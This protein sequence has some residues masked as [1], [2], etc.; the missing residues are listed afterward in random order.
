MKKSIAG[1]ALMFLLL[2]AIT[3]SQTGADCA[4][5]IT[6]TLDGVCRNYTT[7]ATVDTTLICTS[8]PYSGYSPVT[9]FSFTTDASASKVLINITTPTAQPCEVLLYSSGSCTPPLSASSMCFNDGSGLWAFG[10]AF[11]IFPNTTYKL[12]IKTAVAGNITLCAQNITVANDDCAGATVIG[13]TPVTENNACHTAGPGV[14]AAELCAGSLENT[15]FYRYVVDISGATI[16][17]ITSIDCDNGSTNN[18][19]GMQIGF[20]TGNCSS[21]TPLNCYTDVGTNISATTP[22]LAAGTNVYVAI[23]GVAGSNCVYQINAINAMVLP[24]DVKEFA[25][26]KKSTSNL[27]TWTSALE[28]KNGFFEMERSENGRDFVKIGRVNL[29][30]HE[31]S[32]R[33]Y[34][35]EDAAAP[36]RCYYRLKFVPVHG[37]SSY[38]KSILVV[39]SN[40]QSMLLTFQNPVSNLLTFNLETKKKSVVSLRI[41]SMS[42]VVKT[43][44]LVQCQ[45]GTNSFT[46]SLSTFAA[47]TYLLEAVLDDTRTSRLFLKTNGGQ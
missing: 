23:D 19:T 31:T 12:R 14:T 17:N 10:H 27:L 47:G 20:F 9:F 29:N 32:N 28:I 46:Q 30:V 18:S 15:A 26:W 3:Y 21:L 25:A 36:A 42:G 44:K 38:S 2:P 37:A 33:K 34:Q 45:E 1:V 6:L 5:A 13:P 11:T 16:L 41:I 43:L 22:S 7:S 8:G 39:R 40:Q 4:N 35:F 24:I